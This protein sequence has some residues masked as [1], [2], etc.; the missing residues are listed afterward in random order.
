MQSSDSSALPRQLRLLGFLPW[1]GTALA[2]AGETRSPRFRRDPFARDVFS[3]PGRA[4][5]A[6]P[7]FSTFPGTIPLRV[8]QDR[9]TD[10]SRI[11]APAYGA[12]EGFEIAGAREA[13]ALLNRLG[14]D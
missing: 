8:E 12:F 9:K 3:D 6:A 13:K 10:A 5:N 7:S 1:P 11:L 2:I 14:A 4:S